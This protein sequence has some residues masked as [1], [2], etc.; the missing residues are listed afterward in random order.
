[1]VVMVDDPKFS[2]TLGEFLKQ[3]QGG[4]IQGSANIGM[5]ATKGS[6]LVS[7]N[8]KEVER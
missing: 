7:S 1:M 8:D 6:L 5:L 3:V 2:K 4:L